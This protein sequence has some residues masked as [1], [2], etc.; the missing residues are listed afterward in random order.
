M[1]DKI[2]PTHPQD[3]I[4]RRKAGPQQARVAGQG[5]PPPIGPWSGEQA[6]DAVWAEAEPSGRISPLPRRELRR[7]SC[8]EGARWRRPDCNRRCEA[9]TQ[10]GKARQE[11]RRLDGSNETMV[12]DGK[13][14]LQLLSR[15]TRYGRRRHGGCLLGG[16]RQRLCFAQGS[17]PR[18]LRLRLELCSLGHRDLRLGVGEHGVHARRG[19]SRASTSAVVAWAAGDQHDDANKGE[20]SAGMAP[21]AEFRSRLELLLLLLLH[22]GRPTERKGFG[23]WRDDALTSHDLLNS[24]TDRDH[25]ARVCPVRAGPVNVNTTDANNRCDGTVTARSESRVSRVCTAAPPG[26]FLPG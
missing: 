12:C 10:R 2:V 15:C 16:W 6:V 19:H 20:A 18:E 14:T 21:R 25:G 11:P 4:T 26:V 3:V 13:F 23:G 7:E 24:R 9:S 8:G 1:G 17:N 5:A 22:V